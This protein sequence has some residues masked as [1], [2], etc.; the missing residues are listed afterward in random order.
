[1]TGRTPTRAGGHL[2]RSGGVHEGAF[3]LFHE[4]SGCL[5]VSRGAGGGGLPLFPGRRVEAVLDCIFCSAGEE[6]CNFAP[7]GAEEQL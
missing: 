7:T 4:K 2:S 1:M 3:Q 6:S 5:S